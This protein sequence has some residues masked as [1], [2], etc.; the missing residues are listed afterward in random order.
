L[1]LKLHSCNARFNTIMRNVFVLFSPR[2]LCVLLGSVLSITVASASYRFKDFSTFESNYNPPSNFADSGQWYTIT[3]GYAEVPTAPPGEMFIV[4]ALP[5]V[6]LKN[7]RTTVID[8]MIGYPN[9]YTN[10]ALIKTDP[11][12]KLLTS[13]FAIGELTYSL[14]KS[15][16]KEGINV[17]FYHYRAD[18]VDW[19]VEN[20]RKP[21]QYKLNEVAV[22]RNVMLPVN[23]WLIVSIGLREPTGTD[24]NVEKI[25]RYFF[26]KVAPRKL[27]R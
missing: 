4:T 9:S 6:L 22:E 12:N 11:F 27:I 5:D 8:T 26:I 25:Y 23:N 7:M 14:I 16:T 3:V 24:K 17:S 21:S 15:D 1:D 2:F 13:P 10:Y 20:T 18:N 19:V